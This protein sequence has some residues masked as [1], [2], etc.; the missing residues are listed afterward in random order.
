MSDMNSASGTL[1]RVE[2]RNEAGSPLPLLDYGCTPWR[3]SSQQIADMYESGTKLWRKC[4]L[5]DIEQQLERW[6]TLDKFTIVCIDGRRI[7]VKNP[8]FGAKKLVW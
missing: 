5:V 8:G 2:S 3:I 6:A 4:D 1:I 7:Q